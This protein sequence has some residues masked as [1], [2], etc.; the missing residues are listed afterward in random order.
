MRKANRRRYLVAAAA[1]LLIILCVCRLAVSDRGEEE[2]YGPEITVLDPAGER[3]T[4]PLEEFLVGVVAA[5]MPASFAEQ[6]LSAQAV[7]ARTYILT[8]QA[9]GGRHTGAVVCCD[10][11]CCQAW[12][13]PAELKP[14]AEARVRAA[15]AAT[16]GQA[17]YYG[18]RLAETPFCSCCG[19]RTESAAAVWGGARPWLVSVDCGFCADSP[20]CGSC[21]V[22]SLA[23]AAARLE[24]DPDSLRRLTP[25]GYTEGGRVA[26][27]SLDGRR[28]SGTE[29]R[30]ALELPSAAFT[31]LILGDELLV[32][33]L[34][35]GHGVGLCQYGADGMA[36]AGADW[37]EIVGR[38]YP[39]C[40]P[41]RAY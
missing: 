15:V 21:R 34:G 25:L 39:G 4:E 19:G 38:Y 17:L 1:L 6:A 22:F 20:R 18:G 23:D 28:L 31:W 3:V 7:A 36:R 2:A 35:F 30:A 29:V 41:A 24:C 14:A 11:G 5:E 40:T 27:V 16:A 13:D 37:R 9:A 10:P 26:A 33:S 12:R 32:A 8:A